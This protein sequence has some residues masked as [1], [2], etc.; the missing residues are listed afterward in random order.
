MPRA[1]VR[2]FAISLA[3]L[4]ALTGGFGLLA[5]RVLGLGNCADYCAPR[6][7]LV[8]I[9]GLTLLLIGIYGLG[10]ADWR[11]GLERGSWGIIVIA[12]AFLNLALD[13]DPAA[14]WLNWRAPFVSFDPEWGNYPISNHE[15][16]F[17]DDSHRVIFA[18]G[19]GIPVPAE[20][21]AEHS[22]L[23]TF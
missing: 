8:V 14:A 9:A 12:S 11:E 20:L 22:G 2:K 7:V 19:P 5:P 17:Y 6:V 10:V 1:T 21:K 13:Q 23:E 16:L 3:A 15:H 18:G 4:F